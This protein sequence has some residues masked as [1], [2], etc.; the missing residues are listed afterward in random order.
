M[1]ISIRAAAALGCAL[2][3]AAGPAAAADADPALS[4]RHVAAAEALAGEDLTNVLGHCKRIG[5][6][7]YIPD[8]KGEEM[9]ARVIGKGE[10]RPEHVFDDLVFLGTGWV[11]AWAVKT[12]DG[13]ILIDALNNED[14]TRR[15]IEGGLRTAGLDPADI[16]KIIVLHAHGDHY[17][18]ATYLKE[19]YGAE[20][21]MSETDWRQ[22][23]KPKL[24]FDSPRWGRPPARDVGVTDGD[25]VTL[26]DTAITVLETPG[27]TPGTLS[28]IVPVKSGDETHK[29]V[30]WG[31][32]GLNFGP[33]AA[34][35]VQM[36]DSQRRIAAMAG[37]EGLDVFLS[38]HPGLDATL[39]KLDAR[40]AGAQG[41]PFVIGTD[42]VARA[43]TALSHCVAAQLASFAPAATPQD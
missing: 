31:G 41:D 9:L 26:G 15:F 18:G 21:I 34:R 17:G 27:H 25:V 20:I 4:A 28:L 19:K 14:E 12:S 3:L 6:S 22:L 10:P 30:I 2:T 36:I 42:G 5:K 37:P 8:A 38:N 11:S 43:M 24:Q 13:I 16:R 32:N 35:F 1:T 40:A 39:A 29:A 23:E 33:V 7:F